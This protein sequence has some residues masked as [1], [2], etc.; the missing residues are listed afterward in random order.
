MS[1]AERPRA[2][3]KTTHWAAY[4][5]ALKSRG[6]LTVWLDRNSLC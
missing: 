3:Y 4:N 5:A 2:K 1:D 6:P